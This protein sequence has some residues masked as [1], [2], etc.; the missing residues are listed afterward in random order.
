ME[1]SAMPQSAALWSADN[2]RWLY[3]VNAVVL[4]LF[5]G[6][7]Y[8]WSNFAGPLEA[9]FGWPRSQSSLVF[10]ICM[11]FFC[12]GGL[13]SGA[14]LRKRSPRTVLLLCAV[15]VSA[16]F[17]S[18]SRI[19]SFAGLCATYSVLGGFGIG[20]GYN[21]V[22]STV[23]RWF[24]EKPGL[25]SGAVLLGFGWGGLLLGTLS[26]S[27]TSAFGWRFTFLC[28]GGAFGF[29]I[30]SSALFIKGPPSGFGA[31]E[32][33]RPGLE[34]LRS[35]TTTAQMLRRRSFWIYFCWT[36]L[37][38][39]AGLAT[40]G[41]SSLLARDLGGSPAV[42]ALLT[43]VVSVSNGSSRPIMG[44]LCD[45]IGIKRSMCIVSIGCA[46]AFALVFCALLAPGSG[47]LA[48]LAVGYACSGFC[49]GGIV[50]IN[51]SVCH[52]FYGRENY[53]MNFSVITLHMIVASF[54]GPF[55]AGTMQ[56]MTGSFG[57]VA[58]LMALFGAVGFLL[59]L[60]LKKA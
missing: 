11:S 39:A 41:H 25:I 26:A 48:L 47:G 52:S 4:Y 31:N 9:E 19:D 46:F 60:T 58:V 40:V 1:K 13:A 18:A 29:F 16:G 5:L 38:S 56:T 32:L 57:G 27:V 2:K 10:S 59:S 8:A 3:V 36:I 51:S 28:L 37:L 15:C 21:C 34:G 43:G 35:E 23:L 42:A 22:L 7:V 53:A 45:R 33:R 12:I 54:L 6:L 55:L 50:P 14:L 30:V 20:L 49:F 17:V 24:P 44:F